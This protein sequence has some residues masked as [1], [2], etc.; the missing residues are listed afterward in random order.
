MKKNRMNGIGKKLLT[1][2]A[3]VLVLGV[4][5]APVLANAETQAKTAALTSESAFEIKS[6]DVTLDLAQDLTMAVNE[7]I[8]VQ[9]DEEAVIV[10]NV[11]KSVLT[12]E[13]EVTVDGVE[14]TAVVTDYE[15][16][17]AVALTGGETYSINYTINA[18]NLVADDE[19]MLNLFQDGVDFDVNVTVTVPEVIDTYEISAPATVNVSDDTLTLSNAADAIVLKIVLP[20]GALLED[21]SATMD[22]AAKWIWPS[23]LTWILGIFAALMCVVLWIAV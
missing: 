23:L 21:A 15:E 19:L 17:L 10:R 2:L 22:E 11:E 4:S 16:V 6:Y 14:A 13:V 7:T 18:T 9:A 8:S 3:A 20:D 12:S 1:T 5:A